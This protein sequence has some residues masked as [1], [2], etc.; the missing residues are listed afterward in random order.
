LE[1]S[2]LLILNMLLSFK[3]ATR[4]SLFAGQT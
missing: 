3:L 2:K 1:D 4:I